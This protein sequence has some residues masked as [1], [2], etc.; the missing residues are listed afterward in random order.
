M[1]TPKENF[2]RLMKNDNPKWLGDPW[3]CFCGNPITIDAVWPSTKQPEAGQMLVKDAFGVVKNRPVT[4]NGGRTGGTPVTSG[5]HKLVKDI[6]HWRDF[7]VFPDLSNLD[8][9]ESEKACAQADRENFLLM[10]G[11]YMGMFEY[12]HYVMGFEDALINYMTEPDHMYEL[13]SAYTDFKLECVKL[14]IDHMKPDIIHSH[15]DWGNKQ[16]LFLPPEVWRA[17]IKPQYEKLYGYIKSRG[18]MVQHHNDSV[19][20]LLTEDMI[21]LEIDMWQGPIAQND[22]KGCME[23]AGGRLCLMGGFDMQTIDFYP[24]DEEKIRREVRRVTDSYVP[25]GNFIPCVPNI[26]PIYPDVEAII[27]DELNRYGAEYAAKHF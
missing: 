27:N 20:D 23:K 15:D 21:D 22:I 25:L 24:A 13:L 19:S 3:S 9:S 5:D 12:S 7:V 18:V 1:A 26:V 14:I 17:M 8:W 2:L 4:P 16:N 6:A 10:A 11:T